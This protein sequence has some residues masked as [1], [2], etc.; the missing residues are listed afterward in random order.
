MNEYGKIYQIEPD[1]A[2]MT[3]AVGEHTELM[4]LGIMIRK[5]IQ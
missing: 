5:M 4:N 2:K 3:S 1:S